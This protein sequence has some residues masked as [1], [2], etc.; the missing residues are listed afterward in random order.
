MSFIRGSPSSASGGR[1]GQQGDLAGVLHGR[2]D[3]A[4]VLQSTPVAFSLQNWQTFFFGLR[5]TALA[6]V[7]LS[8][9]SPAQSGYWSRNG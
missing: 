4:L 6:I 1:V 5:M 3:V 2:G 7:V 8:F 9:V